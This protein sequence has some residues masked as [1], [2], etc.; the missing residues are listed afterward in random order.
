MSLGA[1]RKDIVMQFVSEAITIS[2]TGGFVGVLLGGMI[3]LLIEKI[4]GIQ[5]II[6]PISVIASFG[7]SI[8][9]G[10]I[11]GIYPARKASLQD[12]VLSLRAL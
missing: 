2:L 10:L 7:I 11:F 12:P 8:S 3:S 5:T 6:S 1:T 9:I 4:T